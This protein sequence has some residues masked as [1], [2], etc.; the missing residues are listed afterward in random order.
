MS[1][2]NPI[3]LTPQELLHRVVTGTP[4]AIFLAF[5]HDPNVLLDS[6]RQ[7]FLDEFQTAFLNLVI[8]EGA[9][10][11]EYLKSLKID[12]RRSLYALL[13]SGKHPLE[14]MAILIPDENGGILGGKITKIIIGEGENEI[15][16]QKIL[17]IDD[18]PPTDVPTEYINPFLHLNIDLY[19]P[20]SLTKSVPVNDIDHI[21][22]ENEK[23]LI[24]A[25]DLQWR[26]SY[27]DKPHLIDNLAPYFQ[28]NLKTEA[29][30]EKSEK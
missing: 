10:A 19:Q 13:E 18:T 11:L 25:P 24:Q 5:L 27:G 2:E 30:Q 15:T 12:H 14:S 22:A 28:S 20:E 7:S 4:L 16:P 23:P 3:L 26:Q 1:V 29:G 6:Y 8:A 9:S 21:E 17:V